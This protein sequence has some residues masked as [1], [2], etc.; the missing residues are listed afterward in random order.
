M[1]GNRLLISDNIDSN[2]TRSYGDW[3]IYNQT[4]VTFTATIDSCLICVRGYVVVYL[5][6][7]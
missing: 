4:P 7:I 2:T 5:T 6:G 3:R 1:F